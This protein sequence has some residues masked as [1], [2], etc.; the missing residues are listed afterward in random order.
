[1]IFS[2]SFWFALPVLLIVMPEAVSVIP[3]SPVGEEGVL[4]RWLL[5][6]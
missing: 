6:I 3:F 2:S 4:S 1:M 5:I